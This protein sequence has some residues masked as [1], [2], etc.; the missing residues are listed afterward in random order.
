MTIFSV[1]PRAYEAPPPDTGDP[2]PKIYPFRL[3]DFQLE[4]VGCI[5]DNESVLVAAHT[6]AGK[7]VCAEYAIAKSLRDERRVVYTS[8]IKALSNQ[9]YRDLR[10]EFQDVGLMTGDITVNPGAR[11]LVMTT[12]ILRSM[13][14]RGAP[15]VDDL[16]WVVY[17]E[18]HYM[19]DKERG[20]VWEESIVL[21]PHS[22]RFVF[23][24]ATIPNAAQFARWIA[25][26]HRQACHVVYTDYRPTPLEHY[27]FA[28]G[29]RDLRLLAV[30][31]NRSGAADPRRGRED[32]LAPLLNLL[33]RRGLT[34]AIVFAFTRRRCEIAAVSAQHQT[35]LLSRD[36]SLL[37][38]RV[39]D[40]VMG[41]LGDDDRA[42][43]QVHELLPMLKRGVGIHHGG[44]L[45]IVRELVEILFQE[46]LLKI[47]FATET[48]AIGINM[49]ARTVVFTE[50]RKFDGR[51]FRRLT[52]GEFI[53]MSGRAGRRGKDD[54]GTVVQILT[55]DDSDV[56]AQ[57]A[58]R[59]VD[60]D[61]DPLNSSY[62]VTYNMLLNSARMDGG[63]ES[64]LRTSFC[65]HQRNDAAPQI[66]ERAAAAQAAAD[67]VRF[68]DVGDFERTRK[69]CDVA[70]ALRTT[71]RRALALAR[72]PQH[73][74]RW[75]QPGR[76]ARVVAPA[77]W[78]PT[79]SLFADDETEADLGLGVIL[80]ARSAR[81]DE[82]FA[83]V[84]EG[85][86][87]G[88]RATS[89]EDVGHV[90]EVLVRAAAELV[91]QPPAP[92][93]DSPDTTRVVVVPLVALAELS[94]IRVF[95]PSDCRG[96][97]E[98]AAI[99]ARLDDVAMRFGA[100]GE[101]MP[102]LDEG[103]FD[104]ASCEPEYAAAA[105]EERALL[106]KLDGTP[107]GATVPVDAFNARQKLVEHA[108]TLR[109]AAAG[110][111]GLVLRDDL[112][113]MREVLRQLGHVDDEGRLTLKGRAASQLNAADELVASEL[114]F[115]GVFDTLEPPV[116]AA[117]LSCTI[118]G[119]AREGD[120]CSP[121][122][123]PQLVAPFEK[124]QA[125]ARRVGDAEHAA[126][127]A[128]DVDAYVATFSKDLMELVFEWAS[129]AK[130]VEAMKRTDAFE[131]TVIRVIR[132]L[133]ELLRQL[134][135]AAFAAGAFD[136]ALK[137]EKAS[138]AVRRD[139]VFAA[140]LYSS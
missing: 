18:I 24:S 94:A 124:L 49:P 138:A 133:D 85:P 30:E 123:R 81:G 116:V 86:A 63:P 61:A 64:M 5:D 140:S 29:S 12:E 87:C 92:R 55:D 60:G 112:T 131:G 120:E 62:R 15:I 73:C 41:A 69:H 91:A 106:A 126:A 122:I 134:K 9:K 68:G 75:L 44:L 128:V 114:L 79:T 20:V 40:A 67:A 99:R 113:R 132:R 139:I 77:D 3:D 127:I 111:R 42:M 70:A 17:D 37:V 23:L 102:A 31:R 121:S 35:D 56:A 6:S 57:A 101:S 66:L 118:P 110:A 105:A 34:P 59:L 27:V 16:A 71:Q 45:P 28:A 25:A 1:Y 82:A 22:V 46:G 58:R 95:V 4:A 115:G 11:C 108:R 135:S 84:A 53:Q 117:L 136:V 88:A 33:V 39:F 47:L 10:H 125:A 96:V 2:P 13:L 100:S 72:R 50:T 97:R 78:L 103:D 52:A 38:E 32:A 14:Y 80:R 36:E 19:R 107:P 137:F 83:A 21:L 89:R 109:I 43:P 104:L 65:Q 51:R 7:T 119:E 76:V 129:G 26:T 98:R 48:F 8:P 54:K 93:D 130:F 90:V 74:L